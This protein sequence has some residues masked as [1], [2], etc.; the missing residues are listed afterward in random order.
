MKLVP[1]RKA[2]VFAMVLLPIMA[3]SVTAEIGVLPLMLAWIGAAIAW[4]WEPPR[5]NLE[6]WEGPWTVLT[7][8]VF[9]ALVLAT[10]AGW[11]NFIFTVVYFVLFLAVARLFQRRSNREHIQAMALS[12]VM[13]AAAG[14]FND[15][16][17]FGFFFSL[18]A[19]VATVGLT[20]H[21]LHVEI[22]EHHRRDVTRTRVEGRVLA[23]TAALAA[24][25]LLLAFV[26]FLAFPRLGFGFF[27][28]NPRGGLQTS[29]FSEQVELGNHGTIRTD[30]AVVMR[31]R[32]PD[33]PPAPPAELYFRGMALDTFDGRRWSHRAE[34]R[35]PISRTPQGMLV[36]PP[37]LDDEVE[38]FAAA[39]DGTVAAEV[40]LQPLDTDVLFGVGGPLRG[41][42]LTTDTGLPDMLFGRSFTA[43]WSDRVDLSARSEHGIAYMAFSAFQRP[44]EEPLR[45]NDWLG[46]GPSLA[47]AVAARFEEFH[48]PALDPEERRQQ[49]LRRFGNRTFAGTPEGQALHAWLYY[50][51]LPP[52]IVTPRMRAFLDELRAEHPHPVDFARALETTLATT[53]E[54]TVD[55]P[56]P[57]SRDANV[58]DEFLFNWQRGHCEYFA[59][60]MVV[61][62][63]A[64]GIPARIVNGFLGSEHNQVGNYFTVRQAGAHSW[65]EVLFPE[66]GWV[67]FEPTPAGAADPRFAL[68]LWRA[69]DDSLDNLRML[70][71]QWVVEYDMERQFAL[72]RSVVDT[73]RGEERAERGPP[74]VSEELRALGRW[75]RAR[76]RAFSWMVAIAVV[77]GFLLRR[78]ARLR[79]PWGPRDHALVGAWAALSVAGAVALWPVSAGFRVVVGALVLPF[80]GAIFAWLARRVLMEESSEE[81]ERGR[82]LAE[83]EISRWMLRL[84]REAERAGVDAGSDVSWANVLDTL[85]VRMPEYAAEL[86]E[87]RR[88]YLAVRFG[89]RSLSE[90]ER[91]MWRR[92]IRTLARAA[93]RWRKEERRRARGAG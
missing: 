7:V 76:G 45:R 18:Y 89:G 23:L 31:V 2:V 19:L 91:R 68:A 53:L 52:D 71:F 77:A 28:I 25:I 55:I 3:F 88:T 4:F 70:W 79:L 24:V 58:V 82:A 61:L 81:S 42:S 12:L 69:L 44:D 47:D 36:G 8:A 14:V 57:S 59:T 37:A 86:G 17:S 27:N 22:G 11:M 21:H 64:E 46:H 32:F 29:G 9:V 26:F 90:E 43:R 74:E 10:L 41:L 87:L 39:L 40:Y 16:I 15:G 78:R 56:R 49:L 13:I 1:L 75:M 50:L 34:E 66:A 48:D 62:L 6:R 30:S 63:R 83:A 51:Q 85:A 54:W 92:R 93:R 60:A 72:A 80:A 33:G 20:T 35:M 5:V 84:V 38:D 65:V 73:L 67:P